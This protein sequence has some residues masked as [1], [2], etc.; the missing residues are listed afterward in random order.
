VEGDGASAGRLGAG[1]TAGY[2]CASRLRT[3]G[4]DAV[5]GTDAAMGTD[6][7]GCGDG[8]GC[9]GGR[10]R[11]REEAGD[12]DPACGRRR[13]DFFVGPTETSPN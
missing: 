13:T 4:T 6:G 10:S 9:G 2:G 3:M 5:M 11:V 8:H 12:G 1:V 7:D